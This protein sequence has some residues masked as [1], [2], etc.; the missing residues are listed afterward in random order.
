MDGLFR[1]GCRI[2]GGG[3]V[4]FLLRTVPSDGHERDDAHGGAHGRQ[5]HL[6]RATGAEQCRR[7]DA[8]NGCIAS[9]AD[10]TGETCR[11][12]ECTGESAGAYTRESARRGRG[13]GRTKSSGCGTSA[14]CGAGS[15]DGTFG[16]TTGG[17]KS[18]AAYARSAYRSY[19]HRSGEDDRCGGYCAIRNPARC[20]EGVQLELGFS[21]LGHEGAVLESAA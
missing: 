11:E 16:G 2:A 13:A 3:C 17:G 15:R 4:G 21:L 9:A 7:I 10:G 8:G 19:A 1:A 5:Q 18:D 20:A 12:H 6:E 14:R